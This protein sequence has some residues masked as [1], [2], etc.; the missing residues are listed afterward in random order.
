MESIE[1]SHRN[2]NNVKNTLEFSSVMVDDDPFKRI[3][4]KYKTNVVA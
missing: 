3:K 4:N 1:Q 2:P